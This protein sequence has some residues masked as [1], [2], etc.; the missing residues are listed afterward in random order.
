LEQPTSQHQIEL[1]AAGGTLEDR[2]AG[3]G[4]LLAERLQ[5]RKAESGSVFVYLH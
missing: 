2:Q 1:I 4:L 5:Y 3:Q